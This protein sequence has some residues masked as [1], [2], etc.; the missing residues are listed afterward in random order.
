MTLRTVF[1]ESTAFFIRMHLSASPLHFHSF[2]RQNTR[3]ESGADGALVA[4]S[5][6]RPSVVSSTGEF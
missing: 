2:A 5:R 1:S 4:V 3:H 6:P